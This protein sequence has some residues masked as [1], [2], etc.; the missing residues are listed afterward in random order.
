M[1]TKSQRITRKA[2]EWPYVYPRINAK[3]QITSW[4]VDCGGKPR[5]R[6]AFQTKAEAD[7]KAELLRNQRFNEGRAIL[8]FSAADRIDAQAALEL[9]RPHGATLRDAANFY[10]RNIATISTARTTAEASK[11]LLAFK[12]KDEVSLRYRKDL[13]LKLEAFSKSFGERPLHE[14][15]RT[16]LVNWLYQLKVSALTRKNYSRVLSVLFSFALDQHYVV[17]HPAGE[18]VPDK[19]KTKKPGILTVLEAKALLLAAEPDFVPAL[20]LGLFAGLRPESEIWRLDWANIKLAKRIIDIDQSK[21]TMSHRHV[22]ITENLVAWLAPHLRA[23]GAV[24][25][26]GDSYYARLEKARQRA[27]DRLRQAKEFSGNLE[28]W[29]QDCLRHS[30][31]SYHCAMFRSPGDTSLE[32]GHGGSLK[33]FERHYRDRVE[34]PEARAFWEIYPSEKIVALPDSSG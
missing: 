28:N 32:L 4:R 5:V 1:P 30:Y 21:N 31:A 13:R 19:K 8:D 27:I 2:K 7:G 23:H 25:V 33:V 6:F 18:L 29:P 11:E 22:R 26:K 15:T 34:E 17:T 12:E 10:L 3:G 16:E 9:L 20:S 24:T 14:I